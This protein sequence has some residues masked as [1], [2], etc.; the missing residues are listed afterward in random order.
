MNMSRI[1][2]AAAAT[3]F[4]MSA[5]GCLITSG[6][7]IEE[8]GVQ[9]TDASLNQIEIGT[10]SEAWLRAT[11][12]E[13]SDITEVEDTPN[14][15]VLRYDHI[16]TKKDG[17]TVFLIFAGGSKTE[18]VTRTYFETTDGYVSRYWVEH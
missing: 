5:G 7:S 3:V 15:R 4:V 1:A 2:I 16:V 17:G 8:S 18:K 10:T 14:L 9:I 6:K 11:L 13:P 12:G